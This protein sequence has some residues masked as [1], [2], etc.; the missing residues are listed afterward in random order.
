[1][2]NP[3]KTN[4]IDSSRKIAAAV[5]INALLDLREPRMPRIMAEYKPP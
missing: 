5:I 1:M 4:G 2:N 3:S